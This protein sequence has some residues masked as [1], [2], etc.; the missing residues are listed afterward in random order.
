MTAYALTPNFKTVQEYREWRKSWKKAY[1]QLSLDIRTKK[2]A[3]KNA[4]KKIPHEDRARIMRW[5]ETGPITNE[6]DQRICAN[7]IKTN[8]HASTQQRELVQYRAMGRKMM[9]LLDEAKERVKKLR[10]MEQSIKDQMET[11]P[12]NL[13]TCGR[14]EFHYN[15][16][17]N[18]YPQLPMW[19]IRVKGKSYYVNEVEANCSWST[20][21]RENGST[22]GVL[23]FS[24][25]NVEFTA[26]GTAII[27]QPE[28]VR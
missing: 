18:D 4:Q 11:F 7:F 12:L 26:E 19:T 25:C 15:R 5:M 6:S 1:K 23:R 9:M 20:R 24:K 17:H 13:G 14:V 22:K 21:E 16:G 8:E 10:E 27:R 2:L 3:T 28:E